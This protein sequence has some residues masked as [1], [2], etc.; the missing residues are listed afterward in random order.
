LGRTLQISILAGFAK[1]SS[2]QA[3]TVGACEPGPQV[4]C[5]SLELVWLGAA[6]PDNTLIAFDPDR[7]VV[8]IILVI[9]QLT[10]LDYFRPCTLL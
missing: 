3:L 7:D 8:E 6:K 1:T 9:A 10:G 5:Q 4:A 2:Q